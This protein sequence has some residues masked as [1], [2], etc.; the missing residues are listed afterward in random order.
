MEHRLL[1]LELLDERSP[2]EI[3]DDNRPH[4]VK[5]GPFDIDDLYDAWAFDT[6]LFYPAPDDGPAD[7][8]MVAEVPG[9]LLLAPLVRARSGD[10]SRC[11]PIGIYR[12]G[13]RLADQYRKDTR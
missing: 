5:H 10:A 2:F 12:P 1:D 13:A 3:D 11:R 4:L 8:L 6:P 7:W 9:D